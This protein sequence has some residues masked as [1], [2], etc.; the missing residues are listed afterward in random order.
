MPGCKG[1]PGWIV[2]LCALG[3]QAQAEAATWYVA[4]GGSGQGSAAAP[5][6][7]IQDAADAAGPG[8]VVSVAPGVYHET[9]TVTHSGTAAAPI[10]FRSEQAGAAVVSGADPVG[11]LSAGG[12]SGSWSTGTV[13]AFTSALGQEEQC[14]AGRSRL[15]LARWPA[16]PADALSS[17]NLALISNVAN[18][19]TLGYDNAAQMWVVQADV[20]LDRPLPAGD[21]VNA[22]VELNVGTSYDKVSGVVTAQGSSADGAAL[23]TMVYYTAGESVHGGNEVYLFKVSAALASAAGQWVRNG[24]SLLVRAPGDADPN[25]A[26]IE[27]KQR[28]YAFDLSGAAYVTLQGFTV[29]AATV[30]TDH[31]SGDPAEGPANWTLHTGQGNVAAASHILLDQLT[32]DTPNSIDNLFGNIHAQWT[33]NSGV[34]LSGS[35][36]TLQNSTILYADA[37]G[38]SLAGVGNRVLNNRIAESDLVGCECAGIN[39]GFRGVNNL[40]NILP[41]QWGWTWN[42]GEEIAGNTIE[43]SGRA[44]INI[45]A[46]ASSS[47]QPSRVHHNLLSGA[48]L[49]TYDN[50]AIY[51]TAYPGETARVPQAGLEIDH[52]IST[53]SPVGIYLDVYSSGFLIHHN[54][55]T[56]PGEPQLQDATM[57][58]NSGSSHQIYNNTLIAENGNSYSI[59]DWMPVLNDS[60]T[61]VRNNILFWLPALV[62]L[63]GC[64]DHDLVWDGVSGS[65]TDPLF[66]NA[67]SADYSLRPGSPAIDSGTAVPGI[68]DDSRAGSQAALGTPDRG[69]VEYGTPSWV[70]ATSGD[71]TAPTVTL[72]TPVDGASYKL[73]QTVKAYYSCSDNG[74]SGVA[75]C[76]GSA[77]NRETIDTSCAGNH[78]FSVTAIDRA[79]NRATQLIH[80]AVGDSSAAGCSAASG[81][82]SGSSSAGSTPAS[83]S[84]SSATTTSPAG[85]GG[86]GAAAPDALLLAALLALARRAR[87]R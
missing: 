52:N 47:A 79:G 38:V 3:L 13:P 59:W 77:R 48:V 45:S 9:V 58:L 54:I 34:V 85:G 50:G 1:L 46:L 43:R 4:P 57:I 51:S 33:N 64:E 31:D 37:N 71:T 73:N 22:L 12:A 27:C 86:G 39:T 26:D 76:T 16:T 53:A 5:F 17:P 23:L 61:T 36:N 81:S 74:G 40:S 28:D 62:C 19:S 15:T 30:T 87:R 70:P 60:G 72:S 41:S 25:G 84:G 82:S 7:R 63:P 8:D 65:A 68:T 18:P 49:Q 10:L 75:R 20:T 78:T 66:S 56:G 21:W 67:A 44:L 69:A 32:V 2:L 55:V 83:G 24:S 14:F 80:Y 6:G 42:I 11:P 35:Y 29:F